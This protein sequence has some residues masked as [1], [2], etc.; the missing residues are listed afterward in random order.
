MGFPGWFETTHATKEFIWKMNLKRL[1][2]SVFA[3]LQ[4][5]MC[6]CDRRGSTHGMQ[7]IEV[8][9]GKHVYFKREVRGRNFDELTVSLNSDPC[10][11]FDAKVDGRFG[12]HGPLSLYYRLNAGKMDLLGSQDLSLPKLGGVAD[13]LDYKSLHPLD[14]RDVHETWQ[15]RG[16]KLIEVSLDR[17]IICF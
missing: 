12:S 7:D 5:I 2:L 10:A 14:F 4:C 15:S 16:L 6:S 3:L 9:P 8:S 13:V 17:S 11:E 1:F